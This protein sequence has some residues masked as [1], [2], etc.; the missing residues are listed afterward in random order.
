[1]LI[2]GGLAPGLNVLKFVSVARPTFFSGD[3]ARVT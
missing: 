2:L 3:G 1:M